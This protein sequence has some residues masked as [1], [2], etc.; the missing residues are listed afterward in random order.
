MT[1]PEPIDDLIVQPEVLATAAGIEGTLT[2][3]Q[4]NTIA[5]AI[6]DAQD[7]VVAFLGRPLRPVQ[8]VETRR[9]PYYDGWV[10]EAAPD[11][12]IV[13][14]DSVVAETN[15]DDQ[16]T[17]YFTVTYTAGIDAF[18][19]P[20]M[21]PIRRY[22]KAHAMN[23][24]DFLRLWRTLTTTK[25]VIKTITAESQS[26]TFTPATLNESTSET[27]AGSGAP[28]ALP[29]IGSLDKWRLSGRRIYQ[30]RSHVSQFPYQDMDR[31]LP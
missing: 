4:R 5:E 31:R 21:R 14:V 11:E 6:R 2:D 9:W 27:K 28:G 20:T 18:T 10:L 25:G 24:P 26:V 13:Q 22:V 16:P 17:D 1:D 8:Y 12:P 15:A 19:D 29:L 7:D 30:G 3:A 23:S